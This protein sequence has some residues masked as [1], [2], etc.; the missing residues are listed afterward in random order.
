MSR[1]TASDEYLRQYPQFERWI[2]RCVSCGAVGHKPDMPEHIGGEH[3]IGAR[4]L[5]RHFRP[6][7]LDEVGRCEQCLAATE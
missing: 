3:S 7:A 6:L 1:S 4:Y 2:N 5:R